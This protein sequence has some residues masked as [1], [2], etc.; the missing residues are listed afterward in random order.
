MTESAHLWEP[1]HD[2][3]G[4]E[5]PYWGRP[6]DYRD[7]INEYASWEAF[8]AEGGMHC[9]PEGLNVLYRWD[10]HDHR[11][12]RAKWGDDEYPRD[13]ELELFW[14]M[15]RK[16]IMARS[17]IAVTTEDEASVRAWLA[18]HWEY[19]R[20]LWEPMPSLAVAGSLA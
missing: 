5:A 2:Y 3:Y 19:M 11:E 6:D 9:A 15:P 14:M 16:G 13:F 17:V 10:W 7:Y 1:D 8:V 4:P 12:D 18:P 20:G